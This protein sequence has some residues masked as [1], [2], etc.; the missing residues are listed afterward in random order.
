M[1]L[2]RSH[3]LQRF[4]RRWKWVVFFIR[5]LFLGGASA[6]VVGELVERLGGVRVCASAVSEFGRVLFSEVR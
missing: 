2:L 1:G 3:V 4:R 6:V 5:S